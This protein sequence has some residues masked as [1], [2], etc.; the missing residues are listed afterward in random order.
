MVLVDVDGTDPILRYMK[1]NDPDMGADAWTSYHYSPGSTRGVVHCRYDAQVFA[2]QTLRD[3]PDVRQIPKGVGDAT[4]AEM[5]QSK[6][7]ELDALIEE[8]GGPVDRTRLRHWE[9]AV[10]QIMRRNG[11]PQQYKLRGSPA[12]R[13]R[14]W[15]DEHN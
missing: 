2:A 11:S 5:T 14:Q 12:A 10:T 13:S 8:R 6:R 15:L 7:D 1:A 4:Y 3:L 9:D